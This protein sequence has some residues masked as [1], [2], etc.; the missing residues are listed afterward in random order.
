MI[1]KPGHHQVGGQRLVLG[2]ELLGSGDA[3][4][5][6]LL[7]EQAEGR[8]PRGPVEG[9]H[10]PARE[11]D[12]A[13]AGQLHPGRRRGDLPGQVRRRPEGR[14]DPDDAG[15]L[16]VGRRD[17]L[18]RR[19]GGAGVPARGAHHRGARGPGRG[20]G[21]QRRGVAV[22]EHQRVEDLGRG[23]RAGQR[24]RRR[25]VRLGRLS[26]RGGGAEERRPAA[27]EG[28][29]R[30]E[31]AAGRD[32]GARGGE[33]DPEQPPERGVV[34]RGGDQGRGHRGGRRARRGGRQ[35][36]PAQREDLLDAEPGD[37]RRGDSRVGRVAEQQRDTQGRA[38]RRPAQ[39]RGEVGGGGEDH[40]GRRGE[41]RA[42]HRGGAGQGVRALGDAGPFRRR[43]QQGRP[44][45]WARGRARRGRRV[46]GRLARTGQGVRPDEQADSGQ[47]QHEDPHQP[48]NLPSHATPPPAGGRPPALRPDCT[49]RGK[50][51]RGALARRTVV[52]HGRGGGPSDDVSTDA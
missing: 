7:A 2:G 50:Q 11:E 38:D 22:G 42:A 51:V 39:L 18:H 25:G 28:G 19:A 32:R 20:D 46:R 29:D 26:G 27:L 33:L 12:L 30:S 45:R 23:D 15:R 34:A 31:L 35:G 21:G 16:V 49:G 47:H 5:Q 17:R 8:D 9:H 37:L 4:G 43:A 1:S 10:A 6:V 36:G 3:A 13:A 44:G 41:E 24:P 40:H 48:P 14:S 52:G